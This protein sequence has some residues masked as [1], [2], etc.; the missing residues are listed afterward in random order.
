MSKEYK[1]FKEVIAFNEGKEVVVFSVQLG[2]ATGGSYSLIG[3]MNVTP[4]GIAIHDINNKFVDVVSSISDG[5]NALGFK[6]HILIESTQEK[7]QDWNIDKEDDY[8]LQEKID[9]FQS[10]VDDF[11]E[12]TIIKDN[13]KIS[14]VEKFLKENLYSDFMILFKDAIFSGIYKSDF[15]LNINDY[16]SK[17]NGYIF[18]QKY[19]N[20]SV[21][22]L[23]QYV[24]VLK[25]NKPYLV[26][27]IY[28]LHGVVIDE[29]L[30]I[31]LVLGHEDVLI[32]DFETEKYSKIGT[33]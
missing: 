16:N 18:E 11:N 32:F 29:S 7:F 13:E 6:Q 21:C 8:F 12:K 24:F 4:R 25:D 23:G 9:S 14:D 30:Y 27:S 3:V 31:L 5:V 26:C 33:R 10:I 20:F 22:Q 28:E 15:E 1:R 19:L 2:E 17:F